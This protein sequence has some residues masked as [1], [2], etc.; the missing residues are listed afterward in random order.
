[1]IATTYLDLDGILG[2][3]VRLTTTITSSYSSL[4]S[5]STALWE[6]MQNSATISVQKSLNSARTQRKRSVA[7]STAG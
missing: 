7:D 5:I 1:M 3:P 6:I 4:K 2:R